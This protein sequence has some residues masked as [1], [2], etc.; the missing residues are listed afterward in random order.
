MIFSIGSHVDKIY[1]PC[2]RH[3]SERDENH[4]VHKNVGLLFREITLLENSDDF[5]EDY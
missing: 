5:A 1:K 4:A 3:N 2:E